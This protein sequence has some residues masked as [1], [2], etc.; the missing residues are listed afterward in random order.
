MRTFGTIIPRQYVF[1]VPLPS[2]IR[3]HAERIANRL[4]KLEVVDPF[5]EVFSRNKIHV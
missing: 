1:I 2:R 4:Q 5:K 3:I